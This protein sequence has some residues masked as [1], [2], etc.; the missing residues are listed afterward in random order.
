M[1]ILDRAQRLFRTIRQ[2]ARLF[3][4]SFRA[5]VPGQSMAFNHSHSVSARD[6]YQ[7]MLHLVQSHRDDPGPKSASQL[8]TVLA[9]WIP[10]MR[11]EFPAEHRKI[12]L[13]E[14]VILLCLGQGD[15]AS[16]ERAM[17]EA[18]VDDQITELRRHIF[19]GHR[20]A[21]HRAAV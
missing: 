7:V 16:C 20:P 2:V 1:P 10:P 5:A 8:R 13:F 15:T 4:L 11:Q 14:E 18:P 17:H 6:Y 12:D 9:R 3:R 19:R 21:D